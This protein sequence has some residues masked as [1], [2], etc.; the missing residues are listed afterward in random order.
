MKIPSPS[1]SLS[2]E[3]A[4]TFTLVEMMISVTVILMTV[5]ALVS[6]EIYGSRVYIL[7]ATKLAAVDGG[8]DTMDKIRQ[9]VQSAIGPVNI[10]NYQWSYGS[11][12]NFQL[13]PIG[14]SQVGNALRIQPG[15]NQTFSA[16]APYTLIFLQPGNGTNFTINDANNNLI[17]TNSL[18]ME[19]F[20]TNYNPIL[21]NTIATYI[22]NQQVFASLDFTGTNILTT[23]TGN[24]LIQVTLNFY[25]WEYPIAVVSLTNRSSD[26]NA[27]NYYRLQTRIYQR[28][29]ND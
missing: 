16:L 26:I 2:R 7:A 1:N 6:A 21:T 19:T 17:N 20:D 10:G 18:L 23:Y 8:R 3:T 25:Q 27:Y 28:N 15:T 13:I 5:I 24:Q 11:P 4:F 14:Q 29:R 9:Q 12:T 22:T